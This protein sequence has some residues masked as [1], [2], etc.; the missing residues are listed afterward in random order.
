VQILEQMRESRRAAGFSLLRLHRC[1]EVPLV[2]DR[3]LDAM[4]TSAASFICDVS[5]A[6]RR[7]AADNVLGRQ[8]M[9]RKVPVES[10]ALA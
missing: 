8:K 9:R 10:W 5:C 4:N 1:D 3:L 2:F 7:F 6:Q